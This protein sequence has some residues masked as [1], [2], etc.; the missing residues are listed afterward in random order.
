VIARDVL[1]VVCGISAGIHAALAPEQFAEGAGAGIGFVAAAVGLA[2]FAVVLTLRPPKA[3]TL[4][5][6]SVL[7]AGLIVSY[8]LA[9]SSGLP[10]VHPE[11][12]PVDALA[13][14]TKA[15]EAAG[16]LA[17]LRLLRLGRSGVVLPFPRPKGVLS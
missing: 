14:A 10:V 11:P 8:A 13:V 5:G 16:L 2:V 4:A 15:I 7:L 9:I 1:I 12:E 17:A 3:A 6:S